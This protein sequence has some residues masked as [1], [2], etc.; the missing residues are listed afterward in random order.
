[1]LLLPA[2]VALLLT[3][4]A[5]GRSTLEI[6]PPS[7][8]NPDRGSYAKIVSVEDLRKFE[9]KPEDAGTPSL[10][11]ASEITDRTITSRAVARKRGGFGAALGDILLPPGQSVAA[12]VRAAA[13][14]AL[15]DKGY[16]VV[17]A[18]S[19]HYT[20]AAPLSIDIVQFW[21]WFSPGFASVRIDFKGTL[22]LHGA[23]ILGS[24]PTS[25]N[26]NV[27]HEG[28]AIFESD[29]RDLVQRGVD[30]LSRRIEERIRPAVAG[31]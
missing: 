1:V 16:A 5:V 19:P 25:V 7:A 8:V 29:W 14:K 31:R 20:A 17:D 12:L 18:E 30:D 6:T 4:C 24:D 28:M 15:A 13:R 10:Q 22:A 23:A 2:L 9:A 27:T 3:G 11:N 21:S 26:S